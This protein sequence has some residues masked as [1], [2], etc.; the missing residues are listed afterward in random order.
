MPNTSSLLGVGAGAFSMSDGARK[1]DSKT[2]E[3]VMNSVGIS[4]EVP[5]RLMDAVTG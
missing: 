4:Y 3:L 1:E 5:E 2:V